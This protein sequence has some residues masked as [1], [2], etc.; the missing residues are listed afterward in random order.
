MMN[1][2]SITSASIFRRLW[3]SHVHIIKSKT[4]E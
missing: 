2:L 1:E 4:F 3:I